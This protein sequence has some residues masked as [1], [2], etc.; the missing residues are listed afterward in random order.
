[1]KTYWYFDPMETYLMTFLSNLYSS[2]VDNHFYDI[3]VPL[4][5]V[6]SFFNN[7]KWKL[8]DGQIC[9]IFLFS[10]IK[11]WIFI[12]SGRICERPIHSRT[13]N[14]YLSFIIWKLKVSA[15]GDV[16]NYCKAN[17]L[18]S[19]INSSHFIL[20]ELLLY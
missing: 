1:M 13:K 3:F 16:I 12:F 8:T 18:C 5:H 17:W 15:Y 7:N 20:Y 14:N 10:R 4:C 6:G 11:I 2:Y 9:R 19:I